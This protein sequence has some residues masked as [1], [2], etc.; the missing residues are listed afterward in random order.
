MPNEKL[1]K[2]VND[3][4]PIAEIQSMVMRMCTIRGDAQNILIDDLDIPD[5]DIPKIK[6]QWS[7][8]KSDV[9]RLVKNLP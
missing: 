7:I 5:S 6:K 8:L 2:F 4:A 1:E 9:A 3:S